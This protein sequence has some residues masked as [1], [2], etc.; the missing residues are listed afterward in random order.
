MV[1]EKIN[2]KGERKEC[3]DS[4]KEGLNKV[5]EY[6]PDKSLRACALY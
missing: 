3:N 4:W 2:I 1:L 5:I 6:G